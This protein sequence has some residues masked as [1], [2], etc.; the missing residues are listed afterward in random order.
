VK[1]FK[2]KIV[3]SDGVEKTGIESH[4]LVLHAGLKVTGQGKRLLYT[5]PQIYFLFTV[6]SILLKNHTIKRLGRDLNPDQKLRRLLGCPLPYRGTFHRMFIAL[7]FITS[8]LRVIYSK[9]KHQ[10]R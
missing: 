9:T 5:T 3:L 7:N 8:S 4:G 2:N 6:S 10:E 1:V